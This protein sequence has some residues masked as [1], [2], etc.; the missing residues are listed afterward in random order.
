LFPKK[1]NPIARKASV[2][3]RKAT[4]TNKHKIAAFSPP[5]LF[6]L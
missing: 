2:I 3:D 6:P 4:I 5:N 1:K